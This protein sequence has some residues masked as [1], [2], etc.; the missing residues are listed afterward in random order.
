MHAS[1]TLATQE[2]EE[3]SHVNMLYR[4][5][6]KQ[7]PIKTGP[8]Q[9]LTESDPLLQEEAGPLAGVGRDRANEEPGTLVKG[10]LSRW[11]VQQNPLSVP[12]ALL[13]MTAIM[14]S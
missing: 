14:G 12:T 11:D 2:Q 8:D 4:L 1:P 9:A 3:I 13:V 10:R 6:L 7:A 5:P